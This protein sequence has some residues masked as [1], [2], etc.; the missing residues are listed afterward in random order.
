MKSGFY[1]IFWSIAPML[2]IVIAALIMGADSVSEVV[3]GK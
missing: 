1:V 3:W 2:V